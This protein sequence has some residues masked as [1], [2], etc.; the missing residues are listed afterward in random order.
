MGAQVWLL[1]IH[2]ASQSGVS[3]LVSMASEAGA[4]PLRSNADSV[5][6][7][8]P[9]RPTASGF[10]RNSFAFSGKRC[11]CFQVMKFFRCL[12]CFPLL[13][14]SQIMV[15][16]WPLSCLAF[17]F[18]IFVNVRKLVDEKQVDWLCVFWI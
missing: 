1:V 13:F 12:V 10:G 8:Y 6:E 11:T 16:F 17:A 2:G 7:P 4:A 18:G 5:L 9:L 3:Y 14:I 15:L